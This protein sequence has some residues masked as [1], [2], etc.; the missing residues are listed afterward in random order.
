MLTIA[1]GPLVV[2]SWPVLLTR[3]MAAMYLSVD[4]DRFTH[5]CQMLHLDAIDIGDEQLRWDRRELDKRLVL[6]PRVKAHES[7]Q[8]TPGKA[9]A[10]SVEQLAQAV[11]AKLGRSDSPHLPALLSIRE[12]SERL[13]IGRSTIYRL[14]ALGDLV[15]KRIGRRTLIPVAQIEHIL[16][17]GA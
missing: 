1:P 11:A 13:G 14:I 10:V 3:E 4:A 7:F 16:S 2:Q 15:P 9:D 12:A 17:E 6:L 8:R 5:L